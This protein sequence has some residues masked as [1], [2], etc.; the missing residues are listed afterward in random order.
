MPLTLP[1]WSEEWL[2]P[3]RY[4]ISFGGRGGGKSWA[5]ARL[6]LLEAMQSP[7]RILCARE[8]QASIADSVHKLLSDTI[9]AHE[10]PGF[11]IGKT[12][13]RHANGSQFIFKGLARNP[14]TVK[15]SEGINIVFVEEAQAV[16]EDSWRQL[17]PTIRTE[18]SEI[19]VSFNPRY[20]DDPT[21]KRFYGGNAPPNSIVTPVGWADN[22][23]FP[24]VLDIERRRDKANQDD[25]TYRWIWE[26]A[27]L[28]LSEAQ[29]FRNKYESKEFE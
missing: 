14:H 26:G 7:I 29:I 19:W 23:W 12:E 18:G 6:L 10:L 16:T 11:N 8:Y 17:I 2:K 9:I 24:E 21:C 4:K 20:L 22:P 1:N 13:I 27:Y 3:A 28:E 25:A 15:S 5:I